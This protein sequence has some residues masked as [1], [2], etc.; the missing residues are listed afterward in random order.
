MKGPNWNLHPRLTANLHVKLHTNLQSSSHIKPRQGVTLSPTESHPEPRHTVAKPR[1][2]V[3]RICKE[4]I[5]GIG[6]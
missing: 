1:Q 4:S 2:G 6:K 3:V 5:R